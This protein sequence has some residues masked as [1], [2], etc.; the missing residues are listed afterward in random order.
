MTKCKKS[1]ECIFFSDDWKVLIFKKR[2]K[3]CEEKGVMVCKK[4]YNAI[5]MQ[6]NLDEI[7]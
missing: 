1:L 3:I 7:Q 6:I 2:E 5:K 4:I